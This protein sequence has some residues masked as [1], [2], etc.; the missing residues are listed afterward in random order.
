MNEDESFLEGLA[1]MLAK[2]RYDIAYKGF[3][4][5]EAVKET[6][7]LDAHILQGKSVATLEALEETDDIWSILQQYHKKQPAL[8]LAKEKGLIAKD[9]E[10]NAMKSMK[11][12]IKPQLSVVK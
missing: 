8:K 10:N 11:S 7:G 5:A 4:Y 12:G 3:L 6:S 9:P 1:A 2:V